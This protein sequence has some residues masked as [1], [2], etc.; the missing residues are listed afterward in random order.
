MDACRAGFCP[1]PAV[2]DLPHDH[3]RHVGASDARA[4]R[5]DDRNFAAVVAGK[6]LSAPPNAPTGVRAAPT[7][8]ISFFIFRLL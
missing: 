6:P 4:E 1:C 8:T 5:F 3:L 7:M 2:R